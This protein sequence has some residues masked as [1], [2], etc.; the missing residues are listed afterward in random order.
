VIHTGSVQNILVD[1][2]LKWPNANIQLYDGWGYHSNKVIKN[3]ATLYAI[4]PSMQHHMYQQSIKPSVSSQQNSA[5]YLAPF[6]SSAKFWYIAMDNG[7]ATHCS[8]KCVSDD[9]KKT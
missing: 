8:V 4:Y 6:L 7:T 5:K 2:S 9:D 3:T 1:W